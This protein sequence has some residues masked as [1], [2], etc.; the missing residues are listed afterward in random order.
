M[1]KLFT[2]AVAAAIAIALAG[3]VARA[4]NPSC[5]TS[6]TFCF[7]TNAA[8]HNNQAFGQ[9]LKALPGG[10]FAIGAVYPTPL[11]LES[12][13]L[14]WDG[15]P[16]NPDP[17]DG[18]LG[19]AEA[20]IAKSLLGIALSTSGEFSRSGGNITLLNF[21]PGSSSLPLGL[22]LPETIGAPQGFSLQQLGI[23]ALAAPNLKI[24]VLIHQ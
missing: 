5:A 20:D 13:Y 24:P 1:N 21:I 7:D 2:G 12:V 11:K 8:A 19:L 23:P 4:E 14:F 15:N 9:L 3:G 18:Y 10:V 6:D 22:S 16:G 17:F